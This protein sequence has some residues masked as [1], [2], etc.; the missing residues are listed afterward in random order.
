M[1]L[2]FDA[3][4][5]PKLVQRLA[6]LYPDSAHVRSVGLERVSD[7]AVWRY[8]QAHGYVIVSKDSDFQELSVLLG[9][10][11]KVVWIRR[12]NCSTQTLENILRKN[13]TLIES[14]DADEG[15]GM[16]MLF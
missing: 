15:L 8:A 10:P 11:P 16:L 12:G 1:K 13:C 2:L 6:D 4:L 5:P 9:Y 14:F 3:N 7:Q